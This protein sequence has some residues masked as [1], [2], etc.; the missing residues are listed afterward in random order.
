MP[1][2]QTLIVL[3][4]YRAATFTRKCVESLDCLKERDWF[5]VVVENSASKSHALEL[6]DALAATGKLVETSASTGS[7]ETLQGKVAIVS[8]PCNL[9]FGQGVRLGIE[10][11]AAFSHFSFV[12]LLNNDCEVTPSAL[13]LLLEHA[14]KSQADFISSRVVDITN[15]HHSWFEGGGVSE[16]G[17]RAEHLPIEHFRNTNHR[18]LSGCSL[19][20][21][22]TALQRF[23]LFDPA[24]FLYWED[25]DLSFRVRRMGGTLSMA[26]DAVVL[27]HGSATTG[28]RT[29]LGYEHNTK[30][31]LRFAARHFGPV[32]FF[33]AIL[34][35]AAKLPVALLKGKPG[36]TGGLLKGLFHGFV[37]GIGI[38]AHE[39]LLKKSQAKFPLNLPPSQPGGSRGT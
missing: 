16:F 24:I 5:C 37:Q 7:L 10:S 21:S 26:Y 18:F 20:F 1:T 36:A 3:V 13:S 11:A 33:S 12:W 39:T 15:P 30:N 4:N 29:A 25:A 32:S 2:P 19:F 23:G 35:S 14:T 6:R 8:A 22:R 34:F 31:R 38:F 9:G 27:H 28:I 17:C